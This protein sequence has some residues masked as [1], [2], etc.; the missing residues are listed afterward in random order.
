MTNMAASKQELDAAN[1]MTLVAGGFLL[2]MI[3]CGG[4]FYF[5]QL[6]ATMIDCCSFF[7]QTLDKCCDVKEDDVVEGGRVREK[8]G[9][10]SV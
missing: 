5:R 2:Q 6:W 8:A 3:L 7:G 4:I 9:T 10:S 1:T